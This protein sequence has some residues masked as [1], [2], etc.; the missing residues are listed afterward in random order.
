MPKVIHTLHHRD[1]RGDRNSYT[2]HE[3]STEIGL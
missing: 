2:T 1:I 3:I